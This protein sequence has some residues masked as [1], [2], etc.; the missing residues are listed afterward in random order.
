MISR[1]RTLGIVLLLLFC[2]LVVRQ[3]VSYIHDSSGKMIGPDFALLS[4]MFA[5]L[6]R[7]GVWGIVTGF[8]LGVVE[9]SFR[10]PS[11][12]VNAFV[13]VIVGFISGLAGERV[14]HHTLSIMFL[15]I[16]GLKYVSDLLLSLHNWAE[17]QG[18][19]ASQLLVYSPLSALF[20]SAAGILILIGVS[21]LEEGRLRNVNGSS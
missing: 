18:G 21:F 20:T 15:L 2:H 13:N 5:G 7:G 9:D 16:M 8:V 17:G 6:G 10:P 3:R 4:V 19:L 14:F 12:G 11:F 1:K